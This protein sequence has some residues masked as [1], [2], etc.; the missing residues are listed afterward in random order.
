MP[1][2]QER[3]IELLNAGLDYQ[4]AFNSLKRHIER[5][6]TAVESGEIT[7]DAAMI[8]VS[9]NATDN[10]LRQQGRTQAT[11]AFEAKHFRANKR[12][13]DKARAKQEQKRRSAGVAP[14]QPDRSIL[15]STAPTS[16][17]EGPSSPIAIDQAKINAEERE[18]IAEEMIGVELKPLPAGAK[19]PFGLKSGAAASGSSSAPVDLASDENDPENLGDDM[20]PTGDETCDS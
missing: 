11:L 17:F 15:L 16:P 10:L 4:Q 18:R 20:L 9:L 14:R 8:H 6:V 2:T 1:F 5:A 12:R 7:A 13:N 19:L 3:A